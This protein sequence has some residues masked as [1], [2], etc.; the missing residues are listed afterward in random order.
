MSKTLKRIKNTSRRIIDGDSLVWVDL[1]NFVRA[2]AKR[3]IAKQSSKVKRIADNQITSFRVSR[4]HA[5]SYGLNALVDV[6]FYAGQAGEKFENAE[7]VLSHY[8]SKG[9]ALGYSPHRLFEPEF[10]LKQLD[11][12]LANKTPL[13]HYFNTGGN[14]GLS[15]GPY[16]DSRFYLTKYHWTATMNPLAHYLCFGIK[17]GHDPFRLFD[18]NF[19][20]RK[21]MGGDGT[22]SSPVEHYILEGWRKGLNPHPLVDLEFLA[23][24]ISPDVM[25][26]DWKEDPLKTYLLDRSKKLATPHPMFDP[27]FFREALYDVDEDLVG[28]GSAF[29]PDTDRTPLDYFLCPTSPRVNPSREFSVEQYKFR[30]PDLG[31][32]NGLYH[33]IR[34]GRD[35]GRQA[36]PSMRA[37][38]NNDLLRQL[39]NE[40]TLLAP[41]QS[42]ED[43][44]VAYM[45]REFEPGLDLLQKLLEACVDFKPDVIFCL[46]QFFRGGAEKYGSK[47]VNTLVAEAP[48]SNFLV[49]ATDGPDDASR[50]W[51]ADAPNVKYL[52]FEKESGELLTNVLARFITLMRPE[53]VINNNSKACWEAYE[54]FGK[55]MSI[56]SN[57]TAC[58]FCYDFDVNGSRVGY[59]RD[60]IRDIIPFV[61]TIMIDNKGFCKTLHA[62]FSLHPTDAKKLKYL[63]QPFEI[64]AD[65]AAIKAKWPNLVETVKNPRV[66]WPSRFHKQKRPDL[67][68]EIAISLP[69]VDFLVWSPD[70]WSDKLA[71]GDMPKNITFTKEESNFA[72]MAQRDVSA[73]LLGSAWEGLPTVLIE[74]VEAGLPIVAN[75]VGGVSEIVNEK[76][77]YLVDMHASA[78]DFSHAIMALLASPEEASKRRDVAFQNVKTQH[79]MTAYIARLKSIGL[80]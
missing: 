71:G 78:E 76:T 43:M 80:L 68:R 79:S 17:E 11:A 4:Y 8:R 37:A 47:L 55:S 9:A 10:Y 16:F 58:L 25:M 35:E 30:Y 46:P 6:E 14:A 29:D 38:I 20:V 45:P 77:G 66:L 36:Y 57:L 73:L 53:W 22:E 74:S 1:R 42:V 26:A 41:H 69:D 33:Y 75:D 5:P 2:K 27:V 72:E 12:P 3:N 54:K 44:F 56:N 48:D 21:H 19:Y 52:D 63:Y 28:K 67:L 34:Y 50:D 23:Q 24:Q 39:D 70:S 13:E 51:Y 40:P 31:K 64:G 15:P 7:S 59:A 18:S 61:D 60:Y 62:D 32:M 65:E 49:I